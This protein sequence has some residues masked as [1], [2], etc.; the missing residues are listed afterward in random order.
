MNIN[1]A[2]KQIGI[3]KDM[4]RFY[5]KKGLIFPVRLSNNYRDYSTHDLHMII[6]IKQYNALGIPLSTIKEML[7]HNKTNEVSNQLIHQIDTLKEEAEWAYARYKNALDLQIVLNYYNTNKNWDTGIREDMYYL[8]NRNTISDTPSYKYVNNGIARAVY[9]ISKQNIQHISYPED[10]GLLFSTAHPK[11]RQ[12]YIKIPSHH[13]YRT[14]TETPSNTL[15]TI[16][17][18]NDI[19]SKMHQRGYQEE[20]DIFIYQILSVKDKI[21]KD[22]ICVEITVT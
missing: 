12:T 14:I 19:L 4:I 16:P 2:S 13:F 15:L 21:S 1:E 18:I 3:S 11:D 17:Q 9:H 22:I 20:N 8:E 5:E 10:T 6:L 7:Y